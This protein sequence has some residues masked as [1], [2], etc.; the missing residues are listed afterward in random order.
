MATWTPNDLTN[1]EFVQTKLSPL[2]RSNALLSMNQN[3][4]SVQSKLTE[5]KATLDTIQTQTNGPYS[6]GTVRDARRAAQE[7]RAANAPNAAALQEQYEELQAKRIELNAQAEKLI[8]LISRGEEAVT[9]S[10]RAISNLEAAGAVPPGTNQFAAPPGYTGRVSPPEQVPNSQNPNPV[11]DPVQTADSQNIQNA[12]PSSDNNFATQDEAN[13]INAALRAEE[14]RQVE[15][16]LGATQA[17]ADFIKQQEQVQFETELGATQNEAD[18]L[19]QA[20]KEADQ[21]EYETQL[22]ATQDEAN[23][24]ARAQLEANQNEYAFGGTQAEADFINEQKAIS[25]QEAALGAA[26]ASQAEADAI[27]QAIAN[28]AEMAGAP[29]GVTAQLFGARSQATQQDSTNDY[30]KFGDWRVRL[31]LAPGAKYLYNAPIPGI[32]APLRD[33]N[34]VLFPYVPSISVQY[35]ANY[36]PQ[37]LTHSNYKIFQYSNSSVDSISLNCD[38]TAQDAKEARYVLA[39]IHFF[40]SVTKMFYGQDQNPKNGTPPPLCYLTGMGQFQFDRHPLVITSFNMSLPTDVDY[41]RAA[42]TTPPPGT[43]QGGQTFR[44]NTGNPSQTRLQSGPTPIGPGGTQSPPAFNTS[45]SGTYEATYVPTKLQMQI[46]AVP[47]VTR[48]DISNNFSLEKYATG[49]L[50]KGSKNKGGAGIW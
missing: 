48:N 33:T 37:E 40:R 28:E 6:F 31:Q 25:D 21:L 24:I 38:F 43:N 16:E 1:P 23:A 50:L 42:N 17:E 4:S 20:Q 39:V 44:D 29:R 34:G 47:I 41:I 18:F 9:T 27:N 30:A 12:L 32:L 49:E 36:S 2:D 19:I 35:A 45:P 13:A 22:G 7:A 8:G 11:T 5:N 3:L 15:T 10:Q 26:G 46:S 14:Q